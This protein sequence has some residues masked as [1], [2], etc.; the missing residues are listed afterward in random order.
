[1][2][3]RGGQHKCGHNSPAMW[4]GVDPGGT[5]S[6]D[7]NLHRQAERQGPASDKRPFVIARGFTVCVVSLCAWFHCVRGFTVCMVSLCAWF[8]CVRGF[9]V[10][11]VSL[12]AWF[13]CVHGF[14]VCVVSLCAYVLHSKSCLRREGDRLMSRG[15]S[16]NAVRFIRVAV[17]A[18]QEGLAL[19]EAVIP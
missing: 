17:N 13:H 12:C 14:T 6:V 8:H 7:S 1:V 2:W 18:V 11:M 10:C 5:T 3:T 15:I 4:R 9:T 19:V 16:P